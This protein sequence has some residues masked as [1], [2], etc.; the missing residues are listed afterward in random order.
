MRRPPRDGRQPSIDPPART[1]YPPAQ[2]LA[3]VCPLPIKCYYLLL[4]LLL[5]V[6]II[7]WGHSMMNDE[8]QLV[9]ICSLVRNLEFTKY[10]FA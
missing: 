8:L 10:S 1:A 7:F 3:N 4:L 5:I 9:N 2:L 6:V